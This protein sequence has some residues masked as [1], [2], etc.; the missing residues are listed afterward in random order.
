MGNRWRKSCNV[1]IWKKEAYKINNSKEKVNQINYFF[2]YFN[3]YDI[4]NSIKCLKKDRN[5]HN[6]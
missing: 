1:V 6:Y 4:L 5:D 2:Q 3:G